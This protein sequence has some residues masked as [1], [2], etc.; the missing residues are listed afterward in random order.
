[1]RCAANPRLVGIYEDLLEALD[2]IRLGK[3]IF[4]MRYWALVVS[5]AYSSSYFPLIGARSRTGQVVTGLGDLIPERNTRG[6]G[7][8]PVPVTGP[9]AKETLVNGPRGL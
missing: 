7:Q 2:V 1:M 6:R 8:D 3:L 9:I 5:G 4:D